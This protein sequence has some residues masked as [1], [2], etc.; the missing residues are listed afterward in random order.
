MGG[1]SGG[2]VAPLLAV[3]RALQE[4]Y[5]GVEIVFISSRGGIEEKLIPQADIKTRTISSGKF[6]RYHKSKI[7]NI[8]DITTIF[9][10]TR[11]FFRFISGIFDSFKIL[12]EEDPD[13]VFFKGGSVSLPMGIACRFKRYPYFIHESDVIPGL[14]NRPLLKKAQKIFVSYPEKNFPDFDQEK[15]IYSGTPIRKDILEGDKHRA[16]ETFGLKKGLKTILVMGGSQGAR[17][18]NELVAENIKSYLEKYQVIHICGDLDY[19]WLEYKS[20]K[21]ERKERY[22]LVSFLTS[23]LRDAYQIADV[24][25][26]RAGNN[27]LTELSALGKPTIVIP[28]ESS[29]DGHQFA[30]AKV[31]SRSGAVCLMLESHLSPGKLFSQV[32]KILND[33][34]EADFMSEK[35]R[36]FYKDDA[37]DVIADNLISFFKEVM[38]EEQKNA[39]K[40]KTKK[41]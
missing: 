36:E 24:V 25:V 37:A 16:Y 34:E 13:I 7:L 21:I 6:R 31:Y 9:K 8:I 29:A 22:K 3:I 11:D 35:I 26:S 12:S 23:E 33:P 5:Q 27:V 41:I 20:Q 32:D 40:T 19:D 2:H 1:G 38:R 4:K 30:N 17:A 10:N 18:I 14:A 39:K 15:L 28:L